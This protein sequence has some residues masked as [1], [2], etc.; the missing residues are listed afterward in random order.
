MSRDIALDLPVG[1]RYALIGPNG[2]GKTTLINLITGMLKPDAGQIVLG[3]EDIT[4]LEPQDRVRKRS[5]AHLPDQHAVSG[6]QRAGGG[7]AGGVPNGA[8]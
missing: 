5:G 3:G 4:A 1:G 8:A 7:D 2:A 6:L